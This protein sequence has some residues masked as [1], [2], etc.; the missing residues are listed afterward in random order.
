MGMTIKDAPLV[1]QLSGKEKI[2]ISDGSGEPKSVNIDQIKGY[3]APK[4][5]SELEN[6]SGYAT[7]KEVEDAISNIPTPDV[8]GQISAA[9]VDYVK[10]VEGKGL[11]TNDFT[12]ELKERLLSL[13]P[14]DPSELEAE[15]EKLKEALNTLVGGNVST[16]IESFNE[17]LAFLR[18]VSDTDTLEGIISG[19]IKSIPTK[20]SQ[21]D[22]DKEYI[23]KEQ[24]DQELS[25]V[26][27]SDEITKQITDLQKGKSACVGVKDMVVYLFATKEDK[28]LWQETGAETWIDSE[29]I[30]LVD[31]VLRITNTGSDNPYFTVKQDKAEITFSF[32]SLVKS[33]VATDYTEVFEDAVFSVSVDKGSTGTWTKVVDGVSVLWGN[34]FTADI[35][36]Y[37]A[38]GANRVLVSAVGSTS[39]A[40]GEY[41][42]TANLTAM[43]LS[44]AN[45]TWNLPFME[46]QTYNLGGVNIGGALSK[47]LHISVS[48]NGYSKDYEENLGTSQYIDKAYYFQT[49]EFPSTGTGIYQVEMWLDA[50]GLESE[51]LNYNLM[52]VALSDTSTAQLVS[53]SSV[54]DKVMNY[55]GN[56]LFDYAVYNG[57]STTANPSI[58]VTAQVGGETVTIADGTI[59]NIESEKILPYEQSIEIQSE[60]T[61]MVLMARIS[62]GESSHELGFPIDNTLSYPAT[63]GAVFS[64]KPATRSNA[65]ANREMVVN[66]VNGEEIAATYTRMAW[67]EGRDGYTVDDNG[68]RCL[69]L[70]ARN[71]ME[72]DY[73]PLKHFGTGKTIEFFYKAKNV[74]DYQ[75]PIITICDDPTSPTFKG[76][77]INPTNVLLHSADKR[78]SD[79]TQ[80]IDIWDE[81]PIHVI[82]T[83]IRSYKVTYGNLAQIY[84]N[85]VKARSFEFD[86]SDD[87]STDAKIRLGSMTT[88]T[89][90]YG[91]NVYDMGF[92]KTDAER[93]YIA[94]LETPEEKKRAYELINATRDDLGNISYDAVYGKYNTM[95]IEMLDNA[96]LPHWGLSKEY[97][98]YCNVEFRFVNLPR[99]Y[100]VKAWRFILEKCK[101]EGQG[102]TSMNYWIWNLRFRLDK[103]DNLVVIYPD[104]TEEVL[105]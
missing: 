29:S 95:E 80:G 59:N 30:E 89:Y 31:R 46:G 28:I 77:R 69:A 92:D 47:V 68:R 41:Y 100:Q 20:V 87:W 1:E 16:A 50:N 76:V 96:E 15:I 97:S 90:I 37:L 3:A 60:Q 39:K 52:C 13:T 22:N 102:T 8:G 12:D 49:L 55:S 75:E 83:L 82:C 23:T 62:L 25:N 72:I 57:G 43:Y 71:P 11:S 88:D 7:L 2:P 74:S 5:V 35:K 63:S 66:A 94:S 86:S 79:L 93:N 26:K 104:G 36:E 14:Y 42:M 19:I 51:H 98:A 9:L 73:S 34:T 70:D 99:E 48:G 65:D 56:K 21:L 40:T 27:P 105:V 4:N 101:I 45:F 78:T 58:L 44:P 24:L 54:A 10:K 64:L 53:V 67:T 33:V 6:D 18:N 17:I 91:L 81:R 84:I 38:I 61:D 103:S 85:G 32:K